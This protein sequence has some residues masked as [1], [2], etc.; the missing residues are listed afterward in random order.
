MQDLFFQDEHGVFSYRVAGICIQND[1][2]L[3]QKPDND[4]G[5]AFPGGQVSFGETHEETL[6]REFS[7]ETGIHI[8]VGDLR[9]VGELFFP[10]GTKRCQ[11][12]CLYYIVEPKPNPHLQMRTFTGLETMEGRSSSMRFYW[13]PL[14][15][16][17]ELPVYPTNASTLLSALPD[18]TV[19]HFIYREI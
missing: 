5:Y 6:K 2:V 1:H 11:Q 15:Q 4:D 3:L 7:E 10:W 17:A 16:V 9:W 13:I 18:G 12:I 19:K 8:T 14:S